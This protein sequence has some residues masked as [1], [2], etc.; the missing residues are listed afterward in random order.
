MTKD[1][2]HRPYT[3]E[4]IR[5]Q[6]NAKALMLRERGEEAVANQLMEWRERF[7]QILRD[8][9]VEHLGPR[10][11]LPESWEDIM[12]HVV[13]RP[14]MASY[15]K[16][17]MQRLVRTLKRDIKFHKRMWQAAQKEYPN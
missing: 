17:E 9:I 16:E 13:L 15:M 8:T 5:Q 11:V 14:C 2:E 6:Y 7:E 3:G 1:F 12:K 4:D 10:E